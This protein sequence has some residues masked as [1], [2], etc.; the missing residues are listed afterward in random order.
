MIDVTGITEAHLTN[1]QKNCIINVAMREPYTNWQKDLIESSGPWKD[2]CD[3]ITWTDELPPGAKPHNES[4]Y[5][6]KFWAFKYAFE[7]GYKNVLWLDSPCTILKDPTPIFQKIEADG[8][9]F[10]KD[11]D[12]LYKWIDDRTIN[13][14]PGMSRKLFV[15]QDYRLFSG[16]FIGLCSTSPFQVT[17]LSNMLMA[18]RAGLFMTAA[19]D[20]AYNHMRPE[21]IEGHRHDES[22]MSM[23]YQNAATWLSDSHFQSK[24]AIIRTHHKRNT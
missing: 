19:E 5:G 21:G 9:Y 20:C 3:L 13:S 2:V 15:D 18:E 14:Y 22:Y 7:Q 8:H 11:A 6:F 12:P 23:V 17:P 16:T 10:I 1:P 24:D 4:L